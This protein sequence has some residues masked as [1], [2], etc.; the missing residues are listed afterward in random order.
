MNT[1]KYAPSLHH[2][3][4]I[5][6]KGYDYSQPGMYFVTMVTWRR[7][8]LFGK[9]INGEMQLSELGKIVRDEWMRS[10][11]MRQEIR[12]YEDEFVVMP[13]H[14]H[15]IVWIVEPV[16]ADSVRP[17]NGV[18]PGIGAYHAPQQE[19][20]QQEATQQE[21]GASLAPLRRA[22]SSLS[23]F[24]AGFKAAVT[25]RAKQELNM[26]GIWQRNY[27]EHIIRN[28]KEFM[29]I[30]EYIDMNPRK[31]LDDQLYP[32]NLYSENTQ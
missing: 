8:D 5:R 3:R 15:G 28:E 1:M 20:L 30:W 29:K 22:Q 7:D 11:G 9:I 2:R 26:I 24:V 10:N 32:E 13:N 6:L 31:W 16:G 12:V 19:A 25:S 21:A 4:S 27:Y 14:M 18:R 23:S 17:E